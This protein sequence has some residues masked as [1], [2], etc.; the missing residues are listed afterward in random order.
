MIVCEACVD[1]CQAFAS[2][3]TG[4]STTSWSLFEVSRLYCSTVAHSRQQD[5]YCSVQQI[6][7]GH[8]GCN[9]LC[10]NTILTND[11]T[12]QPC[13]RNPACSSSGR[14]HP[15]QLAWVYVYN[16]LLCQRDSVNSMLLANK[17]AVINEHL[18]W[19]SQSVLLRSRTCPSAPLTLN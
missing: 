12:P 4:T 16:A 6:S 10:Y 2:V 13:T 18:T 7:T 15:G 17:W 11:C 14:I 9:S 3:S 8:T 1:L 19:T 5:C